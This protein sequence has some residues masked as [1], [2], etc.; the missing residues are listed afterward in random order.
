MSHMFARIPTFG[1][2]AFSHLRL[3]LVHVFVPESLI[4]IKPKPAEAS[5]FVSKVRE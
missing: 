3:E 4:A 2:F 5:G 1:P